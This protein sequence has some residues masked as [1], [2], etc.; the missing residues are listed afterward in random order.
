MMGIAILG[1]PEG[2]GADVG[3]IIG[4]G[5]VVARGA[6]GGTSGVGSLEANVGVGG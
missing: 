3:G 1:S 5:Y 6:E 2:D 4:G